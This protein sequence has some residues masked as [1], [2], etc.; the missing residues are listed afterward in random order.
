[1]RRTI[2]FLGA[3]LGLALVATGCTSGPEQVAGA[4][5]PA[6]GVTES[7]SAAASPSA[8][9]SAA[10][11]VDASP[12]ATAT[13]KTTTEPAENSLVIGPDGM[14]ALKLGMSRKALLATG[15]VEVRK[16]DPD[17]LP[18]NC[19]QDLA[20]KDDEKGIFFNE[21]L[22]I[23]VLHAR[24]GVVTPEGVRIGSTIKQAQRA[25]PKAFDTVGE[26]EYGES[27]VTVPGNSKANYGFGLANDNKI[28]SIWI[29]LKS[30]PGC[31][32]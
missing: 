1:M 11:S 26:R 8:A 29:E 3:I 21:E 19:A 6:A 12:V 30:Q 15:L 18:S 16:V 27:R 13:A 14:G 10:A 20:M 22:G 23:V 9:S 7:P 4:A 25:Y 5:A 28:K 2:P 17:A 31:I 32:G 24:S